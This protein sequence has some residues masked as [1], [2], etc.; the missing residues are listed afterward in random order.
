MPFVS[1]VQMR[2]CFASKNPNWNCKEWAHETP[3]IK[4]LPE[5]KKSGKPKK[6]RKGFY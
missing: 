4:Q 1:K 6:D 2:K 5:R 3:N